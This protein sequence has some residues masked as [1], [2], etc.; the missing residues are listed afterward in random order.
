MTAVEKR[1]Q[2]IAWAGISLPVRAIVRDAVA[3][4]DGYLVDLEVVDRKLRPTEEMLE[5]VPLDPGWLGGDG[6]GIYGPPED[7]T[8]LLVVFVDGDRESP[9]VAG[10]AGDAQKPAKAV[11]AGAWALFDGRG[12]EIWLDG[13]GSVRLVDKGGA[14]VL[15]ADDRVAI[16]SSIR[17]LLSVL[18]EI[19]DAV[20]GMTTTG[21]PTQHTVDP[22]SRAELAA[23]KQ[24]LGEVLA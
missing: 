10:L 1:L 7:G 16:A 18:E 4:D 13:N 14:S 2:E 6:R 21:S 19:V 23:G 22:A 8:L 5:T 3:D 20:S 15:V 12:G 17:S 9:V 11:P 24:K